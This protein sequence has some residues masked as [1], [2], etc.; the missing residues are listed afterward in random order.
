MKG[1]G[2]CSKTL[3]QISTLIPFEQAEELTVLIK[4]G[5]HRL[6]RDILTLVFQ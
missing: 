1:N 4:L 6:S 5:C 2:Q 3:R